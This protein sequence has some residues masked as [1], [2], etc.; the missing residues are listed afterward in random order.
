MFIGQ[1]TLD[2]TYAV[3]RMV[4]MPMLT[5]SCL[6]D[7]AVEQTAIYPGGLSQISLLLN[8]GVKRSFFLRSSTVKV[9]PLCPK[10]RFSC[11]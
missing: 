6:L 5:L 2:S 3:N 11:L 8:I 1:E 9:H 4:V 7:G 10:G